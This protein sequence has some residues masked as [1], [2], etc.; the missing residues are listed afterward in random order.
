MNS[1]KSIEGR[2][3]ERIKIIVVEKTEQYPVDSK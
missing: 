2:S 1:E 3:V